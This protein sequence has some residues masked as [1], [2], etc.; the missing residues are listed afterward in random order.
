MH[1]TDKHNSIHILSTYFNYQLSTND[2]FVVDESSTMTLLI[3]RVLSSLSYRCT[4]TKA[5]NGE[6]SIL[7]TQ[8]C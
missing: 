5:I 2:N 8:P 1:H 4:K 3:F 7:K 6:S